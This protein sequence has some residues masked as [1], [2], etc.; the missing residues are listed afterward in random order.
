MHSRHLLESRQK[1]S[2]RS[3]LGPRWL[4]MP[5]RFSP[6]QFASAAR[7]GEPR[8][9][10]SFSNDTAWADYQEPWFASFNPQEHL[11]ARRDPLRPAAWKKFTRQHAAIEMVRSKAARSQVADSSQRTQNQRAPL[12]EMQINIPARDTRAGS[13]RDG[14]GADGRVRGAASGG[15]IRAGRSDRRAQH[16]SGSARDSALGAARWA[17]HRPSPPSQTRARE[18]WQPWPRVFTAVV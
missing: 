4:I 7:A 18:S 17:L 6:E 16:E 11:P 2:K 9:Y 15:G 14:Y 10:S 12:V 5:V 8:A 3:A 1:K 13:G